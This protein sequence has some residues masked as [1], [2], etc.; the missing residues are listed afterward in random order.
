MYT[1]P[2]PIADQVA[3]H[4]EARRRALGWTYT[5]LARRLEVTDHPIPALGLRRMFEGKRRVSVDE[6]ATLAR[7]FGLD[8]PW[9]LTKPHSCDRCAGSPPAGYKCL[10]CGQSSGVA[11]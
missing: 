8:N 6:L 9:D 2:S 5:E 3:A 4:V 1:R 7:V 10:D 11:A